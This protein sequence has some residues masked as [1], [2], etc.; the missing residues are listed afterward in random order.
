MSIPPKFSIHAR[1]QSFSHA[2]RGLRFMLRTQ[3]NAWIHAVATIAVC[4]LGAGLQISRIEW[5]LVIMCMMAVWTAEAF[6][7][8]LEC[9]TDLVSP[10]QHP[11]AGKAKDIAAAAV[12]IAAFSAAS[13]GAIVFIPRI[14]EIIVPATRIG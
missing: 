12:L 3:H 4:I 2:F 11:L 14:L 13:V 9:L 8:A 5:C 1:G 6:N 10:G 7:T